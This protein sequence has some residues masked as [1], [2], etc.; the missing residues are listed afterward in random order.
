MQKVL[1][2]IDGI[3]PNKKA[4]Y[5]A[6]GLC[7]RIKA[8][9][10]VLQVISSRNY[11]SYI[12]SWGKRVNH[13]R[14][15]VE[16]SMVAV[17]FAEAGEHQMALA[18]KEEAQRNINQLLPES[19]RDAVHCLL[20]MKSGSPDKEIVQYVNE[21]RDIV[22][23]I[24]DTQEEKTDETVTDTKTKMVPRRM[25]RKLLTPLVVVKG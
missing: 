24:Y 5:Y 4:L 23:T 12:K 9:L 22:L 7:K 15:Y 8:D 11:I 16:D 3:K 6:V 13:A 21:H 18:L 25:R 14:K 20:S 2:A 1:L 19:E 10:R 17:T